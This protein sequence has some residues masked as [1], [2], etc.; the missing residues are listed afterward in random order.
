STRTRVRRRRR[1]PEAV[2]RGLKGIIA[3]TSGAALVSGC[4]DQRL[5]RNVDSENDRSTAAVPGS[6][7]ASDSL[8]APQ[9]ALVDTSIQPGVAGQDGWMYSRSAEAD[10]DG[11]GA[12]ERVVLMARAEVMD[13]RP[14]W[15]DGQ[16][17]QVYVE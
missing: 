7:P 1:M 6:D 11:D 17:W 13:G 14:L 12:P 4:G 16:P 15:D 3:L 5:S 9:V 8:P 10:L 2:L